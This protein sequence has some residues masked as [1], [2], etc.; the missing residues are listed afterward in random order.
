MI[1]RKIDEIIEILQASRK[2]SLGETEI[3]K[4][5]VRD[6]MESV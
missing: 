4:E 3:V 5:K 2:I 1:L 6:N